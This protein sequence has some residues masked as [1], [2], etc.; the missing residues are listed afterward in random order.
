MGL[1]KALPRLIE[2]GMVPADVDVE[3]LL[4]AFCVVEVNARLLVGQDLAL[5]DTASRANHSCRPNAIHTS[6]NG[7]I[8]S[9]REIRPGEE[10]CVTYL[11][12]QELLCPSELRQ[13]QLQDNWGFLCSCERCVEAE[14]GGEAS[15]EPSVL[16]AVSEAE[17]GLVAAFPAVAQPG[18]VDAFNEFEEAELRLWLCLAPEL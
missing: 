13:A 8:L 1:L 17:E 18:K 16:G 9:V 14:E 4:Q 3:R 10:I 2:R 5:F 12:S 7:H 11:D 15:W 6:T